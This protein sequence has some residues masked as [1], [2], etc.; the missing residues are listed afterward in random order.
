MSVNNCAC[1]SE[2]QQQLSTIAR[3][4]RLN[5]PHWSDA[6]ISVRAQIEYY[7]GIRL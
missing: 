1:T 7:K 3:H 4:L 5:Y 6:R 2:K